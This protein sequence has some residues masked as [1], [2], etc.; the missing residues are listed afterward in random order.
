[1]PDYH[2]PDQVEDPLKIHAGVTTQF[3]LIMVYFRVHANEELY[4]GLV[5]W[6][7]LG[8]CLCVGEHSCEA[9]F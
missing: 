8:Y 1:M 5:H 2:D 9:D 3:L 6:K 4:V 7:F